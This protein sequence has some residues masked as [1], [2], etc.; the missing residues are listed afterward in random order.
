M[1]SKILFFPD[2][3]YYQKHNKQN[4]ESYIDIL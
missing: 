3:L 4:G 2:T 1:F